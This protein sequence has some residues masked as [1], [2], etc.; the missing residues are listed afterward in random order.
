MSN[1]WYSIWSRVVKW[2]LWAESTVPTSIASLYSHRLPTYYF[3]LQI[4]QIAI[5]IMDV[6]EVEK[7]HLSVF[8]LE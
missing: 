2:K 7:E 3:P 1:V 8:Y 6:D 4:S 5:L